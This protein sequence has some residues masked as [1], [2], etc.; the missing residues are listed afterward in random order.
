[1]SLGLP[2]IVTLFVLILPAASNAQLDGEK[3][4]K[5]N[6]SACHNPTDKKLI[7]P[8]LA[9]VVDRW[10]DKDLLYKWVKN[11]AELRITPRGFLISWARTAVIS[12][13]AAN[14]SD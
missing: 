8:G 10:E 6:C 7:G 11:S 4:F 3:L 12:P 13:M 14:L 1:M 5:T 9:G 2:L